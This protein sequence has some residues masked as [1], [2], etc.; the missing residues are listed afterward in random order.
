MDVPAPPTR[1]SPRLQAWLPA[2]LSLRRLVLVGIAASLAAAIAIGFIP[3]QIDAARAEAIGDRVAASYR[4]GSGQPASMFGR[5]ETRAWADGW[6]LRWRFRRCREVASLRVL[7][8]HD[9]R[10]VRLAE[11]P[12]CAPTQGFGGLPLKV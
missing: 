12:D 2:G 7:V 8:S 5:R 10:R 9:G 1:N 11:L 4:R 3:R 6:E